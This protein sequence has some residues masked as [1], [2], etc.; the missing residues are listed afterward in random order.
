MTDYD[1]VVQSLHDRITRD[2]GWAMLS[3]DPPE[4]RDWYFNFLAR[5]ALAIGNEH[6]LLLTSSSEDSGN[7]DFAGKI[8]VFTPGLIAEAS[9]NRR[10][11]N[12]SQVTVELSV[13]PLR[14]DRLT[15]DTTKRSRDGSPWPGRL[16]L[17]LRTQERSIVV[18]FSTIAPQE[19]Y[20]ETLALLEH[21]RG[22][23]G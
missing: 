12:V 1:E 16:R 23:L 10:N 19:E 21:V 5:L 15:I 4:M 14:V 8:A 9:I 3:Q 20:A 11:P 17:T 18:P 6:V 7:F 13:R 22:A 2:Q